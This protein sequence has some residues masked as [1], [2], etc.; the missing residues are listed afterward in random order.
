[1]EQKEADAAAGKQIFEFLKTQICTA[2]QTQGSEKSMEGGSKP[3]RNRSRRRHRRRPRT[4]QRGGAMT[5]WANCAYDELIKIDGSGDTTLVF[6]Q[7]IIFI[8]IIRVLKKE[9]DFNADDC[10]AIVRIIRANLTNANVLSAYFQSFLDNI[11]ATQLKNGIAATATV[12]FL[13]YNYGPTLVQGLAMIVGVIGGVIPAPTLKYGLVVCATEFVNYLTSVSFSGAIMIGVFI[14]SYFYPSGKHYSPL[15]PEYYAITDIP[16]AV[17]YFASHVASMGGVAAENK[18]IQI[19]SFFRAIVDRVES[20][21]RFMTWSVKTALL[22]YR[23]TGI[24]GATA[25]ACD[26]ITAATLER[27]AINPVTP[28][29]LAQLSSNITTILTQIGQQIPSFTEAVTQALSTANIYCIE[30]DIHG[31]VDVPRPLCRPVSDVLINTI[32]YMRAQAEAAAARASQEPRV[33][34]APAQAVL[35]A[36]SQ[37]P[38]V[39]AAGPATFSVPPPYRSRSRSRSRGRDGDYRGMD[40]RRRDDRDRDYRRRDDKDGM[41]RD[42]RRRDYRVGGSRMNGGSSKHKKK[43]PRSTN[44]RK[45]LVK[46]VRRRSMKHT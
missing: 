18:F 41:R 27:M 1:M 28:M 19:K 37:P 17:A 9:D 43:Y 31:A 34:P 44:K 29:E 35:G 33:L 30:S 16:D 23:T 40:D 24:M 42:D 26:K 38:Q 25:D 2:L 14:H 10:E 22:Y 3:I 4:I 15:P 20:G 39:P 45:L 11:T 7:L 5:Q 8:D 46:R 36:V 32:E 6:Y 21:I 12:S 13:G